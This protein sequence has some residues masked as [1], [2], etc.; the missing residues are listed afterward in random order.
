LGDIPPITEDERDTLL[1]CAR[2]L[3]GYVEPERIYEPTE[4]TTVNGERPGDLFAASVTWKEILAPLDWKLISEHGKYGLWQRPGK[5]GDGP[6]AT[7][8]YNGL[9]LLYVFSSNAHPF[10]PQTGYSKFTAYTLLNHGGDFKKAA[11]ALVSEGVLPETGV[12]LGP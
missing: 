5:V 8:G 12:D 9:D 10:K 6:S 3:T 7:T 2:A 4:D 1:N 11:A